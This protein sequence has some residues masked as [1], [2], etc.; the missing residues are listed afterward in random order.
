MAEKLMQVDNVE[1]NGK[2]FKHEETEKNIE[3]YLQNDFGDPIRPDATH[4]WMAKVAS[5]TAFLGSYNVEVDNTKLIVDSDVLKELPPS[6]SP[7]FL[8]IWESWTDGEEKQL[9]I[10]PSPK[11]FLQFYINAN[12]EDRTPVPV[13]VPSL[14]DVVN[15]AVEQA[16]LNLV[17]TAETG[18]AGTQAAVKQEYVDG[19][20]KITF[21][22][23]K[24]DKGEK[25]DDGA[26]GKSAYD[27][28]LEQG[29]KG[30]IDDFLKSLIGERGFKGDPGKGFTLKGT[31]ASVDAMEASKGKG[32]ETADFALI[33]SN[34]DDP[35]NS[36][37][38]V[39]DG[40][41]FNYIGDF[42]GAQGIKGDKGD[43][44]TLHIGTITKLP[45]D[46][47][48]SV[49]LVEKG[50]G[51]YDVNVGIPAGK[52]GVS[53]TVSILDNGNIALNGKDTGVGGMKHFQDIKETDDVNNYLATG[54]ARTVGNVKN[55][56]IANVWGVLQIFTVGINTKQV[57]TTNTD[58]SEYVRVYDA[59]QKKWTAWSKLLTSADID[60]LFARAKAAV[61]KAVEDG[62]W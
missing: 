52:D 29:N 2:N 31:F 7:Y 46:A 54:I 60:D 59:Y 51:N 18:E 33:S 53:P 55:L 61:E 41:K 39:W 3:V 45:S 42:S 17:V 26:P 32:F 56:P 25:G 43:P 28:W 22:I 21:V 15:K 47:Q 10:Y 19:K 36:K 58:A 49:E 16:G 14:Q 44:P 23:P 38:Y 12:L 62:K 6:N 11:Q 48:P 57:W 40:T 35:D 24:G 50:P 5:Q 20:N 13:D 34:V 37:L 1:T 30:T 4:K 9:S 8:E 27:I